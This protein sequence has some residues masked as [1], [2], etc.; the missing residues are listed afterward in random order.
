MI[1]ATALEHARIG[2]GLSQRELAKRVGLNYQVIRRTEIGRPPRSLRLEEFLRLA[3]VLAVAPAA[4]L[5]T[6][7][8]APLPVVYDTEELTAAEARLLRGLQTGRRTTRSLGRAERELHLP[9]L[10]RAGLI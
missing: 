7:A 2:A 10:T 8:P 9:R 1:S 6:H 5:Q 3:S 4:L